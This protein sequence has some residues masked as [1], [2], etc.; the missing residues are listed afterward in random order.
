MSQDDIHVHRDSWKHE[1]APVKYLD[2]LFLEDD[3]SCGH[4]FICL[5]NR[6]HYTDLIR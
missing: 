1:V 6:E 2:L 4:H 5:G 3:I